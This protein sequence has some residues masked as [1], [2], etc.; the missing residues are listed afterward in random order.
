[1][2]VTGTAT[3]M[4][5][6]ELLRDAALE[7]ELALTRLDTL[8]AHLSVVRVVVGQKVEAGE[9][10]GLVGS[11][12]RSTGPHLHFE[13]R[14]LAGGWEG[15][16]DYFLDPDKAIGREIMTEEELRQMLEDLQR[17]LTGTNLALTARMVRVE[18]ILVGKDPETGQPIVDLY[19]VRFKRDEAELTKLGQAVLELDGEVGKQNDTL[20]RL[21]SRLEEVRDE[22]TKRMQESRGTQ[23]LEPALETMAAAL[24]T[25]ALKMAA[26]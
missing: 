16:T 9:V 26:A 18:K 2:K 25:I 22:V 7:I 12:G 20:G 11:T 1:M 14:R 10:I 8:Y 19:N 13:V 4:T 6:E 15:L 23:N 24:D 5:T 17:R 3:T 21:I